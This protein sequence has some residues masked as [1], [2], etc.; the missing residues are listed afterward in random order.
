MEE[1]LVYFRQ[2]IADPRSVPPWSE[3]WNANAALV[4]RVFP[5]IDWVRL[6]HRRLLGA[7][8]ILQY[9]GELPKDYRLAQP[10]ATGSCGECGERVAVAST[11]PGGDFSC[12]SCGAVYRDE[13]ALLQ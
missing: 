10:L 3:W 12:P 13:G 4:E 9:N 11:G 2:A 5:L 6:K 8:Q 7:R 1:C